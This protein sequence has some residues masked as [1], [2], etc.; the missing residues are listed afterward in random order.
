[1]RAEVGAEEPVAREDLLQGRA[2]V[3]VDLQRHVEH[4]DRLGRDLL[5]ERDLARDRTA[6]A[7]LRREARKPRVGLGGLVPREARGEH[8]VER[9]AERPHVGLEAVVVGALE[10][11]GREVRARAADAEPRVLA[12]L[13][14]RR[15]VVVDVVGE[16]VAKVDELDAAVLADHGVLE[17]DVEV[18]HV[19]RVERVQAERQLEKV[20]AGLGL[21]Q[22]AARAHAR[23]EVAALGGLE[24][25]VVDERGDGARRHLGVLGRRR[26]VPPVPLEADQ[27]GV[28]AEADALDPLHHV[29][30]G[31]DLVGERDPRRGGAPHHHLHRDALARLPVVAPHHAAV[32][33]AAVRVALVE[34]VGPGGRGRRAVVGDEAARRRVARGVAPLLRQRHRQRV[35]VA[36]LL[37][38]QPVGV[39]VNV[40]ATRDAGQS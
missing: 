33:A 1:M 9:H 37:L 27:V 39:S 26:L 3:G 36:A 23:E 11:L 12:V 15:A 20:L 16:R 22:R 5:G 32:C 35:L 40:T 7:L 19:A 8:R 2:L 13:G 10:H 6:G 34:H 29:D 25:E 31:V 21:G 14:L 4:R 18:R 28:G 30:L 24:D 38:G 17:L